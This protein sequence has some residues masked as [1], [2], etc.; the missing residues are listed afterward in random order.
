MFKKKLT[1]VSVKDFEKIIEKVENLN[2]NFLER[3]IT[4]DDQLEHI[5]NELAEIKELFALNKKLVEKDKGYEERFNN[6]RAEINEIKT[7]LVRNHQDIEDHIKTQ[8]EIIVSLINK[9]NDQS[10]TKFNQITAELEELKDQ[11]DV[12][13]ISY[14]INEKK[15][16]EKIKETVSEEIH[17]AVHEKEKEIL[18]NLWIRELREI[19]SNFDKLKQV[20]PKEFLIQINQI[21][22]TIEA[23]KKKLEA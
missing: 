22:D 12:L 4:I 11:Q 17:K 10:L 2:K 23:F 14:T 15:L 6:M 19:L 16:M 13:R 1:E 7:Q 5:Q 9:F 20:Q 8:E 21:A 3:K 18:M